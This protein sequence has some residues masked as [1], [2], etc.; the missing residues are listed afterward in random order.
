VSGYIRPT[1]KLLIPAIISVCI[2]AFGGRVPAITDGAG[3]AV[4]KALSIHLSPLYIAASPVS[5]VLDALTLLSTPQT[6][7]TFVSIVVLFVAWSALRGGRWL[8]TLLA[9]VISIAL[10]ETAVAFL[11]RPMAALHS[12]APDD[13][14]VDF[15]SHTGASHDVRKSFTAEDNRSWHRSGG[16]DIAYV[17][18]HVKFDGAIAARKRNPEIAG[19]GTSLLTGVEGRYHKIIS[20]IMLGIDERDS[21]LL[22]K[23]GNLLPGTLAAGKGPVTIVALPNRHL[24]SVTIQSLDSLP[25]FVA[26]ELSDA[27]PRGL[28]Q[29]DRE[30]ARVRKIAAGLRL[31][32]VAASNNHGFGRTVA[33]WNVLSIPGWR[34]LAPDSVGSRIEQMLRTPPAPV[35][36]VERTRP[37]THG[38]AV[39]LTLPVIMGQIAGGLTVQERIS[40]LVWIWGI[41]LLS[42][43]Y[44]TSARRSSRLR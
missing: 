43:L 42:H 1:R 12:S 21:R 26:I 17:T 37:H 40:W 35:T 32:L 2:L 10:I 38:L 27:A 4:G 33:A 41:A 39:A 44:A 8:K 28:G 5:R 31:T 30:E 29:L 16:F 20:T 11:P 34:S 6:V 25:H 13:V 18:D 23:R 36:I 19:E 22:N 15:H 7:A 9:L 3:G 24:D 14:I